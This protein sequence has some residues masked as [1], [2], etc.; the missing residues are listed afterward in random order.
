V[1]DCDRFARALDALGADAL[2]P[3]TLAHAASC[4]RCAAALR[5]AREVEALLAPSPA[6]APEGFTERVIAMVR[7]TPRSAAA[8]AGARAAIPTAQARAGATTTAAPPALRDPIPAWVRMAAEPRVA[9]AMMVAALT[10]AGGARL[11][12]LGRAG[13][14][15]LAETTVGGVKGFDPGAWFGGAFAGHDALW[16]AIT[17]TVATLLAVMALPISR[18]SERLWV[19]RARLL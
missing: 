12:A 2:P 16:L 4:A 15:R 13:L 17:V 14:V 18:W 10:M 11:T 5:A 8:M 6:A 9:G 7:E 1:K 3:E 19:R